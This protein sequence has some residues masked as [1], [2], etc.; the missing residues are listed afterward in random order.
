[1]T[2]E[3]EAAGS[4]ARTLTMGAVMVT[5]RPDADVPR[6]IE[7][8]RGIGPV[9]VVRNEARDG[10]G[11]VEAASR[12]GATVVNLP[13]NLGLAS[14]LNIGIDRLLVHQPALD[15][16]ICLDQDS[17]PM[18]GFVAAMSRGMALAHAT[19]LRVGCLGPRYRDDGGG[20]LHRDLSSG[21]VVERVLLFTS[22]MVI[23][24][25]VWTTHGP[26][27]DTYF[28]D[29]VDSEFCLRGRSHGLHH[30]QVADAH[31]QH[32][33]GATTRHRVL[34][35]TVRTT[36]HSPVRLHSMTSNRLRLWR[37][38]GRS[39][40]RWVVT[41]DAVGLL[42]DIAKVATLERGRLVKLRSIMNGIAT[43]LRPIPAAKAGI[44]R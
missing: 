38:Y 13:A 36:N 29:H 10:D 31:L 42:V 39:E 3:P 24:R 28:V 35:R 19:G 41:T 22:G 40:W 34:G 16:V 11:V 20:D 27:D 12:I 30:F 17:A 32:R 44:R 23:P 2:V 15:A 25:D 26:F 8:L 33:L 37:T 1:M 43:A 6:N 4:V 9:V 5:F 7:R 14:A 18:P 21:D